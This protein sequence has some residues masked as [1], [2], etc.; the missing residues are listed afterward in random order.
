RTQRRIVFVQ[1]HRLGESRACGRV[2]P[3]EDGR[4]VQADQDDIVAT[5]D[6]DRVRVGAR[7][8]L[9]V[10]I[11]PRRLRAG[12][13]ADGGRGGPR[14][15]RT[16]AGVDRSVPGHRV[17]PFSRTG[18]DATYALMLTRSASDS[19]ATIGFMS[20]VHSPRRAPACMSYS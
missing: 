1:I 12:N 13:G 17:F 16:A 6:G 4:P 14:D 11:G 9:D 19:F 18:N 3:I 20:S 5:L 8:V 15:Q 10:C 7:D 2:Q